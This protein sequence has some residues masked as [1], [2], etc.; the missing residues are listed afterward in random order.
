MELYSKLLVNIMIVV[1]MPCFAVCLCVLPILPDLCI[2]VLR[3]D[4]NSPGAS[5]IVKW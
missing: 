3:E 2:K 5:K 4:C 1:V